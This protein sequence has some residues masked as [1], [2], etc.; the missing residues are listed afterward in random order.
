M[1]RPDCQ[2][3]VGGFPSGLIIDRAAVGRLNI[4][5]GLG[6][7][8]SV[9]RA[10]TVAR[11]IGME[12][13]QQQ[14]HVTPQFIDRGIGPTAQGAIA[15]GVWVQEDLLDIEAGG[16]LD[17]AFSELRCSYGI[18][19]GT[20]V[21]GNDAKQQLQVGWKHNIAKRPHA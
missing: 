2:L 17:H 16:R 20:V 1:G 7:T 12:P 15:V 3:P 9:D 19:K 8:T 14:R 6:N 11:P 5:P 18:G 4:V 21:I 13:P 10:R